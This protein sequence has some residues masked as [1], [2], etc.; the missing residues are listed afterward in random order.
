[1]KPKKLLSVLLALVML[2][3]LLP[4]GMM[5]VSAGGEYDGE[6][7]EGD[8]VFSVE[9]GEVTLK[10]YIGSA[11]KVVIPS[12]WQGLPVTTVAGFYYCSTIKEV[13]IPDGITT[14]YGSAFQDCVNLSSVNIPDSV[15]YIGSAAF[16]GCSSLNNISIPDSVTECGFGGGFLDGTAF[17]NNESN[18]ENGILYLGEYLVS[19]KETLTGEVDIKNGTKEILPS[20]F[21]CCENI[22][23]INIPDSVCVIGSNA[24]NGCNSLT[25]ITIP[26]SVTTIGDS[27]FGACFSLSSI[28]LGKGLTDLN[29]DFY[30]IPYYN[31]E[32]NW[33]DGLLYCGDYL[34]SADKYQGTDCV[35]KPGTRLIASGAFSGCEN[36][37]TVT[38]PDSVISISNYAFSGCEKLTTVNLPSTISKIEDNAFYGCSS[39]VTVNIPSNVTTIGNNVFENCSALEKVNISEKV[40][41]IGEEV[42]KGCN[43]LKAIDVAKDNTYFCSV[44]GV[45]FNKSKTKLIRYPAKKEGAYSAPDSVTFI[46]DYAFEDC[47]LLTA[48]TI[49]NGVEIIGEACFCY[50]SNLETVILPDSVKFICDRAFICCVRLSSVTLPDNV[51]V[52]DAVFSETC[53]Y[54]YTNTDF[55]VTMGNDVRFASTSAFPWGGNISLHYKEG[56]NVINSVDAR[57][58]AR[59]T[60]V[61]IPASVTSI[62]ERAF[63][64]VRYTYDVETD[65]VVIDGYMLTDVYYSGTKEQAKAIDIA[66]DNK[67]L[68]SAT[69][70]Y[71]YVPPCEKHTY[72]SATCTKPKTCKICGTTS[73]KKLGH[74]YTNSCDKSCNRCKATRTI[75][76]TYTNACDTKCNVCSATRTIKHKY[77]NACDTSCNTC[78]AT[79]K[80]TH[81]YE[82]VTKKA[83]QTANGYTVKRCSV[84]KKETGKT[85]IY[86]AN[87]ISLSKTTYT[88]NGKAQK[89]TVTVKDSKGNKIAT[90]NY[91]ITYA[92][93]R[94]NVGTY[95]VTVK[96]KGNY[97]GTKTLTFKINPVKTTV[98]KLTAAKK[99]LKVTITKKSTQ[100]TG[101]EVQYATNK[102]FTSAKTKTLTSYKKNTL[103]LTGL[104]AKKTYYVRVRTY[105]TVNGKKYYSAWSAAKSMKT[106]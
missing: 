73:G 10:E 38:I 3:V 93:G 104:T 37:E 45:L 34:L 17:Y 41:S 22:T 84:C 29:E 89:P 102:N 54:S 26:D 25:A 36:L 51:Y 33:E 28:T 78:K 79:R 43:S 9:N 97:S 14:I 13:V 90:S 77:T 30:L 66:E 57:R 63:D 48:I 8:F 106:K 80:I 21:S 100:V 74:T 44:D 49:P 7:H 62:G 20:A 27:A 60:K 59:I 58:N 50:C 16:M 64:T 55:T 39:L 67:G 87:K 70:H 72:K 32:S 23:S 46:G 86:K 75:K 56:T 53:I 35:V 91:T 105:K 71:N 18:W 103:T 69:W 1:M 81:K 47:D 76:H 83:T 96:M 42:F 68:K 92:S 99:S 98:S 95:K 85:A 88:Y 82:T 101:Y 94:K 52:G 65:D 2:V 31:D 11:E 19:A 40:Q 12:E 15:T 4:A 5:P 61:Y 24:F 6:F